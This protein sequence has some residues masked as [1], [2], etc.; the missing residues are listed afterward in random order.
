MPQSSVSNARHGSEPCLVREGVVAALGAVF[1]DPATRARC[2]QAGQR[3]QFKSQCQQISLACALR[4][5]PFGGK[6]KMHF[7]PWRVEGKRERLR[8]PLRPR[9]SHT[10]MLWCDQLNC[11]C[12]NQ[13]TAQAL[14]FGS[15]GCCC[16]C[17][18]CPLQRTGM[19]RLLKH[20]VLH[21]SP[22]ADD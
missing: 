22:L 5:A 13:G 20:G 3:P 12:H 1:N 16:L 10:C 15:S 18:A 14:G 19:E 11:Q 9:R 2:M 7:A 17:V 6:P 8:T 21:F 4:F